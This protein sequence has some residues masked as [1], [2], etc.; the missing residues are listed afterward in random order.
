MKYNSDY[1]IICT[2]VEVNNISV[3]NGKYK[4][5]ANETMTQIYYL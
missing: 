5:L 2:L 1:N 4:R 3:V